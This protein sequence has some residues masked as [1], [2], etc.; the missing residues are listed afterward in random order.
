MA[1][2]LVIDDQAHIRTIMNEFLTLERH[3][4]D[5]AENG[6]DG[7]K[8]AGLN[9]YDL[10]I[11]DVIMPHHDGFEVIMALKRLNPPVKVIAITGGAAMLDIGDILDASHLFGADRM[12][13]KPLDFMEVQA[14]VNE[15]LEICTVNIQ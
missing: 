13:S 5:L 6:T 12:L 14:V 4:V 2:I 9:A 10:V 8:L 11:T 15:V 3:E 7:M 1:R